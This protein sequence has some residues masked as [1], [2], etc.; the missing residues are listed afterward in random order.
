MKITQTEFVKSAVT[1][2]QCPD[3]NLPEICFGG[4]SN[5]GKSSIINALCNRKQ[6]ARIS[7]T[8]GKTRQMNYFLINGGQ[9]YLV[10]LP[11]YGYARVS[12][13]ERKLWD[14]NIR[15]Y[16]LGRSSLSLIIQ[17]VDSRH[18]PTDLDKDLTFWMASEQLPFAIILTKG[19]KLSKNRQQQSLAQVQKQL[20]EMN[21]EVPLLITSSRTRQGL[22][23]LSELIDDFVNLEQPQKS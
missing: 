8:P 7:N 15:E 17:L 5:V 1:L 19:D 4:R 16:L 23:D 9:F 2:E 13:N 21:V 14:R 18:E 6:L 3:P 10:D 12:K 22:E 20:L 11:G